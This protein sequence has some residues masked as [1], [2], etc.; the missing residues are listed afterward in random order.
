MLRYRVNFFRSLLLALLALWSWRLTQQSPAAEPVAVSMPNPSTE[1]LAPSQPTDL[2]MLDFAP[3]D[4]IH[5][6]TVPKNLTKENTAQGVELQGPI[7]GLS[8]NLIINS[9]AQPWDLS[10]YL[11]VVLDVHNAGEKEVTL[12]CRAQDPKYENWDHYSE[13]VARV[14]AGQTASVL[15][16]L[17]RKT[18]PP[19]A[20]ASLFPGMDAIPDGY[21][22]HWSGLDPA[23]INKIVLGVESP[24]AQV[25]LELRRLRAVGICDAD[26]LTKPD[27]FP[28]I[29][30]YGQ[31]RHADWPTKIHSPSDFAAQAAAEAAAL[32]ASPRP[33]SWDKYGGFKDGP[34]LQATANFRVDK[35]AG[36]WWLVDPDG[37]LFWSHGVTGVGFSTTT[38]LNWRKRFF[39]DNPPIDPENP[40]VINFYRANLKL[41]YGDSFQSTLADLTHQRLASWG[42]NTM[43]SWSDP[44]LTSQ[45]RTPYTKMLGV[46]GPRIARTVRLAD[47]FDDAF[48]KNAR[49]VFEAEQSTTGKD[50]WCIGY[51]IGNELDWQPA[52]SIVN[53]IL[54]DPPT[55]PAKQALVKL[56]QQRH[57][58]IADLNSTWQTTYASWDALLAATD[59]VDPALGLPDFTA[60]D[61][62]L[63][64]RYYQTCQTE[65]KRALPNKLNLGSRFNTGNMI[66]VTAAAKYCDVV[67]FN[68]YET[69]LRYLRLPGGVDRPIIIGEFDFP[70]WDRSYTAIANCGALTE[71]RRA[72]SYWYYLTTALDNPQIVGTH[73]FQYLDQSLTGRGDNENFPIGFLDVTDTPYDAL[74]KVTCDLGNIMYTRRLESSPLKT[75]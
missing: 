20:L 75:P 25:K 64:D 48:V 18:A 35:Y 39:A 73:W 66:P 9:D 52:P 11:F 36:K 26:A 28:F 44:D 23:Q 41:K 65:L 7:A 29:D 40:K 33:R 17:K 58:T 10:R 6:L 1:D 27:Y 5:H 42:L 63:A 21:M 70:A 14:T 3:T 62:L 22:P 16:F 50:P 30:S 47:P 15:V 46:G 69:T 32:R 19:K 34:Q 53:D 45:D 54:A 60:F 59:P 72:D 13:S 56:L 49:T 61:Q 37:R 57:P 12:V 31:F 38:P 68:K 8:Q 43:A 2:A 71:Q 24:H 67:S 51:F 74:T 55:Q 4:A